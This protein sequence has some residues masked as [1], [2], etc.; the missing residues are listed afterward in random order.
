MKSEKNIRIVKIHNYHWVKGHAGVQ[1]NERADY[2]AKIVASYKSTID[3][4]KIPKS[5]G[6]Q[7]LE[8]HYTKIWNAIYV[9]AEVAGHSIAWRLKLYG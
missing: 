7:I 4:T 2:L 9:N 6:K 8:D 1:G 5:R 3:Y